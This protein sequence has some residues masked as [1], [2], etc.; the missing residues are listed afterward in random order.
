MERPLRATEKD[1]VG[2]TGLVQVWLKNVMLLT[3]FVNYTSR[4]VMI[5]VELFH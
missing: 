1:V 4:A 3:E 5:S 2:D